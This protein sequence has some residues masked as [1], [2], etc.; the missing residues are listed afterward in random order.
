MTLR[1]SGCRS[2]ARASLGRSI[3]AQ[4]HL[5]RRVLLCA[6]LAAA[7][8]V[9]IA[10]GQ[11]AP[12]MSAPCTPE[13]GL[14]TDSVTLVLRLE[15][16]G[17]RDSGGVDRG[18]QDAQAL[19][20]AFVPPTKLSFRDRPMATPTMVLY[21]SGGVA[22]ALGLTATVELDIDT[23]GHLVTAHLA[24]SAGAPELNDALLS[25]ARRADSLILFVR[26]PPDDTASVRLRLSAV[27]QF[28]RP[29]AALM[30]LRVPSVQP[31]V[32]VAARHQ[33]YPAYPRAAQQIGLPGSVALRFIVNE[34]GRVIPS[35]IAVDH[36][37]FEEFLASAVHVVLHSDFNPAR[38]G[39]CP[40]KELVQQRVVF[41]MGH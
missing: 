29:D 14:H 26:S 21:W 11:A 19:A 39:T 2:E 16:A 1:R 41:R 24:D 36:A 7:L 17:G 9:P 8:P 37:D 4:A 40:V 22:A 10:L 32:P 6:A 31:T 33:P 23:L 38:W 20:E 18:R 3:P 13:P 15:P 5:T 34:R 28:G 12:S 30:R 35:S 25:A 27:P